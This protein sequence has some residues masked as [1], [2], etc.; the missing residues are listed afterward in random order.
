M[1]SLFLNKYAGSRHTWT[2]DSLSHNIASKICKE[3]L[4]CFH[5]TRWF[6][7]HA[8]CNIPDIVLT[9]FSRLYFW[10]KPRQVEVRKSEWKQQQKL[11]ELNTH[12]RNQTFL[13]RSLSAARVIISED[14]QLKLVLASSH[15]TFTASILTLSSWS[16]SR[17][18]M[19]AALQ[20]VQI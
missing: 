4:Q 13:S 8:L 7:L 12:K 2:P 15:T 16:N 6:L 19:A 5:W 3:S 10:P 1:I 20:C 14:S 11:K 17:S 9:T 18:F